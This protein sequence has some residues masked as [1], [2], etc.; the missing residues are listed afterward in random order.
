MWMTAA[1]LAGLRLR[2]AS[3]SSRVTLTASIRSPV[4]FPSI[5]EILSS[6]HLHLCKFLCLYLDCS[7]VHLYN[8][9]GVRRLRTQNMLF[10]DFFI[11][12]PS[13]SHCTTTP[14]TAHLHRTIHASV[15]SPYPTGCASPT[16]EHLNISTILPCTRGDACDANFSHSCL[17]LPLV[18][19]IASV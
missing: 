9:P 1:N 17:Q 6:P 4:S 14:H 5:P 11:T 13:S 19:K 15:P 3:G 8:H 18:P 16:I 12:C 7:P 10:V 2:W